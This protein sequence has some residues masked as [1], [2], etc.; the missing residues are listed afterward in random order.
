M[1]AEVNMIDVRQVFIFFYELTLMYVIRL[2]YL[3]R[4]TRAVLFH[5]CRFGS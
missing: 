1:L 3:L 4:N 5:V 2:F